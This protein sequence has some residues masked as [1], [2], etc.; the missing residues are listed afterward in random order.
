MLLAAFI[1]LS[2]ANVLA[3]NYKYMNSLEYYQENEFYLALIG[4]SKNAK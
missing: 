1:L 3:G 4:K 2:I